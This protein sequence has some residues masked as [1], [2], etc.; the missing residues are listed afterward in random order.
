M[1]QT[2]GTHTPGPWNRNI[3]PASKYTVIFAGRNTH[4]A[5][6]IP[7]GLPE[8]EVEA[9]CNLIVA[10]PELLEAL[11]RAETALAFFVNDEG[12]SDVEA[13][14]QAQAAIAKAKGGR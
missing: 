10:A 7:D 4:V 2:K 9:N 3:K 1:P 11:E 5:R 8:E 6:V 14:A 13:L 12:E